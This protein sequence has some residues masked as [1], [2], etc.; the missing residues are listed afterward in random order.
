MADIYDKIVHEYQNE[1]L[2]FC[3]SELKNY[4]AAIDCT[5]EVFFSL[6]KK[7]KFL[8]LSVNIKNRLYRD[9]I[10]EIKKYKRKNPEIPENLCD[11]EKCLSEY[12]AEKMLSEIEKRAENYKVKH[13][14]KCKI[15]VSLAAAVVMIFGIFIYLEGGL[16]AGFNDE[17]IPIFLP[18]TK[19]D[20]YGSIAKLA[21][22]DIEIETPH[23]IPEGFVL[24]NISTNVNENDANMVL[25]TFQKDDQAL[26]IDFMRFW[27]EVAPMGIPSDHYNISETEVNGYPAILSKE[28]N[29]YTITFKKE[30][31]VFFMAALDVPYD[32][33]DKIVQSIY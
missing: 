10:R 17:P 27:N 11:A 33:C 3:Y 29:Q 28:D 7:M 2:N 18:T 22:Y 31:T 1:I 8:N 13:T 32:E 5:Q 9:A 21:E 24:T 26:N 15:T 6:F 30:K 25:F 4:Q 19:D 23:Y 14:K 12:T 16:T 20:P